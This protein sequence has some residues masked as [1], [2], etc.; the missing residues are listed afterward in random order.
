VTRS[1]LDLADWLRC[2]QA[3]LVAMQATSDSWKPVFHL[4]EAEGFSCRLL[5][6]RHVKNGPGRPKTDRLDAVWL[7]KVVE[8]GRC[9]PSLVP[10]TPIRQL[11]DLTRYRRTLIRERTREK[12]RLEKLLEDTQIK[13]TSVVS[14]ITGV[15]GRAML[16]AMI[17]GRRDPRTLAQTARGRMRPRL[18]ALEEALTGHFEDHHGWLCHMM[19]DRIEEMTVRTEALTGR[20]EQVITPFAITAQ[21]LDEITEIGVVSAQ[22]LITEIGVDTSTFPTAP[23]L[24]SWTRFA[25][26]HHHAAGTKKGR[27]HREGQPVA[28]RHARRHRGS[29]LAHEHLPRRALPAHHP[30]SRQE[31]GDRRRRPFP[32]DHHLAP[33]DRPRRPLPPPRPRLRRVTHQQTTPPTGTGPPTRAPHRKQAHPPTATRT[34]RRLTARTRTSP[35][36]PDAVACPLTNRFSSQPGPRT[37]PASATGSGCR[38]RC[39]PC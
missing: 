38:T 1:L 19:L 22:E 29:C 35:A 16:E 18:R 9:R 32:A 15:S 2:A 27:L 37:I 26:I 33:A 7:A 31:P 13:L 21:R 23:H 39:R 3:D 28:G 30:P 17:A 10:P 14:D 8:R 36:P 5:N 11:R 34:P 20:I 12:Q 6:A 25:P 24:V 4:L